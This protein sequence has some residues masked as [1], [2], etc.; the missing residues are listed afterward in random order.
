MT[1]A[2]VF[3]HEAMNT[4][5]EFVVAQEDVSEA[6]ARSVA[7]CVFDEVDRLEEELSRFKPTSDIWRLSMLKAGESTVVD[8]ATWDCLS[9]AKAVHARV[10]RTRR[11]R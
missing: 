4:E 5:W 8:F 3:R 11:M 7:R 10:D 2:H 9:L 1:E 6:R